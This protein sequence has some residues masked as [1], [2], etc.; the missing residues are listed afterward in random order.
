MA[1][2][3]PPSSTATTDDSTATPIAPAGRA[4]LD[5]TATPVARPIDALSLGTVV[6]YR[7]AEN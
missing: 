6:V 2:E 5:I 1:T 7:R 3:I 4:A